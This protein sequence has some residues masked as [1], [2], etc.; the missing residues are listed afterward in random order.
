MVENAFAAALTY[1]RRRKRNPEAVSGDLYR[2]TKIGSS[3]FRGCRRINAVTRSAVSG[4][5]GEMRSFRPLPMS[6][7]CAGRLQVEVL[8]PKIERL[9]DAGPGVVEQ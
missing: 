2:F 7:T 5:I 6:R 3:G 9:L 8:R 4:Q 1:C